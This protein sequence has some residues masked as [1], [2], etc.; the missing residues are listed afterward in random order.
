MDLFGIGKRRAAKREAEIRDALSEILAQG[1]VRQGRHAAHLIEARYDAAQTTTENTRH[2]ANTDALN[3]DQ[4]NSY[5]IRKR[6]RERARYEFANNCYARGMVKTRSN[7]VIGSGPRLQLLIEDKEI[8]KQVEREFKSWARRVGLAKK[9]LQMHEARTVDGESFAVKETNPNLNHAV[10]LDLRIIECDRVT[11]LGATGD[12]Y[13]VDGVVLD[14]FGNPKEYH[15]LKQHPGGLYNLPSPQYETVPASRMLHWFST[16]RPEQHRGLSEIMSSLPLYGQMRRYTLAVLSAAEMAATMANILYTE[17]PPNGYAEILTGFDAIELERN[18]LTIAPAGWK[19]GQMEPTQPSSTYK[20]FK[21]EVLNEI[22][23]ALN[24]PY[25]IAAC[26]SSSYNYASGRLDQQT[27]WVDMYVDRKQGEDDILDSIVDDWIAEANLVF[28][29]WGGLMVDAEREYYWDGVP[30]V[31]PVK[32]ADAADTL[33][34]A[35]LLTD[36]EHFARRG[37]DWEDVYEQLSRE[38]KERE[39]LDLPEVASKPES[40]GDAPDA[41]EIAEALREMG[42]QA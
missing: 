11:E 7:F 30:H 39:R 2:W 16:D 1:R 23:R 13:N 37:M 15:V 3:A 24:M 34:K 20:E 14:E 28:P 35:G 41:E 27:F 18:M 38:K 10:K 12:P 25:N 29:D 22:G 9:L 40:A 36:T 6:V 26:D 21:R 19:P 5:S 31:D 33:K 4:A 32:E 42:V 17:I 8:A